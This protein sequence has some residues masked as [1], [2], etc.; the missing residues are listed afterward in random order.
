MEI[1][2]SKGVL[3]ICRNRDNLLNAEIVMV[4]CA[5]N[6]AGLSFVQTTNGFRYKNNHFT[7]LWTIPNMGKH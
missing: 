2:G 6:F 5:Q 3:T 4:A 1:T 7:G